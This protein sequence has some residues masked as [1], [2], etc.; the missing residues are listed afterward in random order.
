MQCYL[1][2]EEIRDNGGGYSVSWCQTQYQNS[3][4]SYLARIAPADGF[5]LCLVEHFAHTVSGTG[6]GRAGLVYASSWVQAIDVRSKGSTNV[7]IWM[8]CSY[9]WQFNGM[10]AAEWAQVDAINEYGS[11]TVH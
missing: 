2:G 1:S 8:F 10:G 4:N 7:G 6:W 11:S 3:K 5:R 9:G